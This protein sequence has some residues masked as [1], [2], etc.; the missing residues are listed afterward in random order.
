[1]RARLGVYNFRLLSCL[2]YNRLTVTNTLVC[3]SD[4]KHLICCYSHKLR[5][6]DTQHKNAQHNDAQHNDTQHKGIIIDIQHNDAQHHNICHY[7]EWCC[8][9]CHVLFVVMVIAVMLSAGN[10]KGGCINVPLTSCLTDLD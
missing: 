7:T 1:M 2:Q 8:A 10:T 3:Y 6:H 9:E 5:R 4:Q